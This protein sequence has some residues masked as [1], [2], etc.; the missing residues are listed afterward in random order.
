MYVPVILFVDILNY[1][2]VEV[3]G[4][5]WRTINSRICKANLNQDLK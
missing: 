3:D 4:G 2:F 5:E 1:I